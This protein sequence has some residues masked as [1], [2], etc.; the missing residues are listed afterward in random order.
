MTI[1]GGMYESSHRRQVAAGN[2]F[3]LSF[4][5]Y[6][7]LITNARR[8]RMEQECKRGTVKQ[9]MESA[10][11]YALTWRDREARATGT[12]NMETGVFVNREQSR[13]NQHFKKGDTHTQESK[14]AI[15]LAR[16]GTKHSEATK[17]RIKESNLG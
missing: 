15:A 17:A 8:Q 4:D 5:Q 12:L 14:D 9:F 1:L 7:S 10:T 2:R 6:L 3:E 13:L 11:G 16:T